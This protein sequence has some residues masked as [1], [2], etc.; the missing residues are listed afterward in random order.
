MTAWS[1][2][3]KRRTIAAADRD[4]QIGERSFVFALQK[5]ISPAMFPPARMIGIALA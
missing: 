5:R 4:D 1:S 3:R 2:A